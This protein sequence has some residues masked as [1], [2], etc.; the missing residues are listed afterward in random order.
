MP[1]IIDL[2]IET[3]ITDTDFLPVFDTETSTTKR[4]SVQG[5]ADEIAAVSSVLSVNT[6]TGDVVGLA[7]AVDFT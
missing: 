1:R 4:I 3:S 2:P 5:L 6:R 7:E